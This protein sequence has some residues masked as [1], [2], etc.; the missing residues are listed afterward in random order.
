VQAGTALM[1]GLLLAAVAIAALLPV[2]FLG[3]LAI[4][5]ATTLGYS[6]RF[7]QAALV[8]VLALAGLYTLRILAGAAAVG[9]EASFWLL[10]F[11]MFFFLSLALVKRYSELLVMQAEGRNMSAGRGYGPGDLE[12]LS[13]L[14]TASGYM[15][16]LVLALYISS[17]QVKALYTHPEA[18]WL[19]CPLLLYWVSRVW[20]M[21]RRDEMHEDPVVF[22]LED[23]RSHLLAL[24]AALVLWVAL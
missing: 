4:Y 7:K 9:V 24:L 23:R 22:A 19:L 17:E 15:A 13:Q 14:G 16:V 5:Y 18:I 20:L 11:S 3:L 6:F 1:A 2:Q 8:D 21:A 12:T 10:A